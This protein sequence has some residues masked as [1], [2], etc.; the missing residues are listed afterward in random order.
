LRTTSTPAGRSREVAIDQAGRT[1]A[2]IAT[3]LI[4]RIRILALTGDL[5]RCAPTTWVVVGRVRYCCCAPPF[6]WR[7]IW[8]NAVAGDDDISG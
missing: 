6:R 2:A 8:E 5:A 4:A 7:L 3:E 1:L